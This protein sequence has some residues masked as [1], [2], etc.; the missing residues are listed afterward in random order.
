MGP[1]KGKRGVRESFAKNGSLR[2]KEFWATIT[3]IYIYYCFCIYLNP[4]A[5]M[6][7][8]RLSL[9]FGYET[10]DMRDSWMMGP[11]ASSP[12]AK[13]WFIFWFQ[14]Y[15]AYR[16]E[17]RVYRILTWNESP[18]LQ[19]WVFSKTFESIYQDV[20]LNNPNSSQVIR[21]GFQRENWCNHEE[22]IVRSTHRD[23]NVLW[24]ENFWAAKLLWA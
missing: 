14:H 23:L 19:I 8:L 2:I 21:F 5:V 12:L 9:H 11:E 7:S 18:N 13:T 3:Y 16:L 6:F 4:F 10:I 22:W 1:A 24:S 20:D 15:T 17:S